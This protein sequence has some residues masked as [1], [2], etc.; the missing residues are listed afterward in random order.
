MIY[1]QGT[2]DKLTA[3]AVSIIFASTYCLSYI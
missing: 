3:Y 1:H 2:R